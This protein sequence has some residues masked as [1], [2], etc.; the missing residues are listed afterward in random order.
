MKLQSPAPD[1]WTEF[2]WMAWPNHRGRDWGW[3][4]LHPIKSRRTYFAA[5]GTVVLVEDYAGYNNGY[6]NRIW[7]EHA[8]GFRTAYNH[9]FNGVTSKF[10]VGQKVAAGQYVGSMGN[11]GKTNG[12]IHLHFEVWR[13]LSGTWVRVDPDSWFRADIPDTSQP[14]SDTTD[15]KRRT[16]LG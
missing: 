9:Y 10:R 2:G 1:G 11:T 12:T 16:W 3:Y 13:L 8:P 6:G 7:V 4:K 15:R 5:P 14:P